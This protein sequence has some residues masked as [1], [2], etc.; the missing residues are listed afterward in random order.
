MTDLLIAYLLSVFA[1]YRV[2]RMIAR[3]DGPGNVFQDLRGA[4]LRAP[5]WV[6]TGMSCPLCLGFWIALIPALILVPI[7]LT[8]WHWSVGIWL[9]IA[10]GQ[11]FLWDLVTK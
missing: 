7:G 6:Q 11:A 9:A 4:L 1:V 2:A 3:E 5:A 10:G 8:T